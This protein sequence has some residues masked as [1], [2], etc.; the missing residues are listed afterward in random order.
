MEGGEGRGGEG[1][2][3]RGE[4]QVEKQSWANCCAFSQTALIHKVSGTIGGLGRS[5]EK[6]RVYRV[7]LMAMGALM[8]FAE[9]EH[10]V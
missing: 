6:P 5:G 7:Y 10:C 1:E 8:T 4:G 2:E 9:L 3:R